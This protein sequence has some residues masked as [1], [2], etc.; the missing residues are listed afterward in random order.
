MKKRIL[1][2]LTSSMF[3]LSISPAINNSSYDFSINTASSIDSTVLPKKDIIGYQYKKVNNIIYRRLYN[4]SAN[5]P[6]GDWE[7]I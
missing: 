7:R 3:I 4:F 5:K 6:L 2:C 1:I